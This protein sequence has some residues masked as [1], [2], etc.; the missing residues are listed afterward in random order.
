MMPVVQPVISQRPLRLWHIAEVY[1][2]DYGGGAAIYVQDVCR[3][4]AER[5]HEIRVLCTE[6]NDQPPYSLRTEFDGSVHIDRL[7][8][9]YFRRRDPG[10]WAL[11]LWRWRA[12]R[13]RVLT[14]LD[15]LLQKWSPDLIQFHTPHPVDEDFIISLINLQ[16]PVVG[17]SHCGWTICPR[18]NLLN[19]PSATQCKGPATARC[20][21]CLYTHYDRSE[22]LA[23]AKLPWRLLKLGVFPAYRLWRRWLVARNVSGLIAYSEYMAQVHR[24]FL[25]AP[26]VHIPLGI[27]LIGLPNDR[28]DRP[29]S[30][31]RFGFMAG[32][33]RHKGI[34]D[35]LDAAA[36]LKRNGY[37]FELHIWGPGQERGPEELAKRSL[38]GTVFLRGLFERHER[39]GAYSEIDVLVMATVVAEAYGRVIQE[40][41]AS[42]VPSIAPASGGITEQIRDGVDGLLYRFRDPKDLERKMASLIESPGMI[43][44][45]SARLRA[46]IDTRAA[47]GSIEDFYYRVLSQY[48]GAAFPQTRDR[49]CIP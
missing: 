49:R 44:E 11:G 45:L 30:P 3:F 41:S 12:H 1:P 20:L 15:E 36:A 21:K 16:V 7:N 26:V 32:F 31:V 29:H 40:A 5:G 47:V 35:V 34:D 19:S 6:A 2:P 46:V 43:R 42:G 14:V 27:D 9:P 17:M 18:L 33:Q 48:T 25:S 13:R 23:V 38:E 10:G 37:E 4:L 24:E 28:P 22:S 8:L 39:W